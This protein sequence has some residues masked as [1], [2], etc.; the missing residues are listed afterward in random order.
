[1]KYLISCL[2]LLGLFSS[3]SGFSAVT[4]SKVLVLVEP[5]P[6][7][8]VSG[9]ANRF[10]ALF[11]HLD[12]RDSNFEVV[13]VDVHTPVKPEKWLGRTVH[14]TPAMTWPMY[15][16]ELGL[17]VDYKMQIGRVISRMRPDIIHVSS[18]G[19]LMFPALFYSRLFQTP[20][21]ASYHTHIPIYAHAYIPKFMGLPTIADKLAWVC[22]KF[23]HSLVDATVV[24]S[25]QIRQ[26]F[27]DHKVP[28]TFLW[29]KGVDTERFHPKYK[30]DEM[31]NR[32]TDGHPDDFL[33]V[34]VGR[35]GKEKRIKECKDILEKM[36]PNV[37]LAIVGHGPKD[38][39][40]ELQEHFKGTNTVFTGLLHGDE[41][42][43]TY[44][45]SDAFLMPSDSET[46]GFVVLESMASEVPVVGCN[47]GGIPHTIRPVENTGSF[48]VETGD[49]DGYVEKLK[50]LQND[51]E[52]CKQ[53]GKRS[54][55]EMLKWSWEDSMSGIQDNVYETAKVNKTNRPENRLFR[56]LT[57][58]SLRQRIFGRRKAAKT[59][60]VTN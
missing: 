51:P 8:Y 5:S 36:G 4:P 22:I 40:K 52:L 47:A 42:S 53:M 35:L 31:R 26:E 19:F 15:S 39:E 41:L 60:E 57:L 46:L 48:L 6:L 20:L 49:I 59:A 14:H 3:T 17:S 45:S 23:F 38:Y 12:K 33:I 18:P 30:T 11:R 55:E 32:L 28:K 50:L 13:T 44:S 27:M 1:M 21:V 29:E 43:S 7:T 58:H 10:Q 16:E 9:Y 2:T 24:T 37:R 34:H 54:R 25:P 56:F